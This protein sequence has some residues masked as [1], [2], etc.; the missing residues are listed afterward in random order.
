MGNLKPDLFMQLSEISACIPIQIKDDT[1]KV[2][3]DWRQV[4][5]EMRKTFERHLHRMLTVKKGNNVSLTVYCQ[6]PLALKV[7]PRKAS[8]RVN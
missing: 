5:Q 4:L 3:E 6:E 8:F 1:R 7:L 2:K